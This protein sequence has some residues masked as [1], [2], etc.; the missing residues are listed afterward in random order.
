LLHS[1]V[2][3]RLPHQAEKNNGNNTRGRK[4]SDVMRQVVIISPTT[5]Y[6]PQHLADIKSSGI[7]PPLCPAVELVSF[8][9]SFEWFPRANPRESEKFC[10]PWDGGRSRGAVERR[11]GEKCEDKRLGRSEIRELYSIFTAGRQP[12]QPRHIPPSFT[13]TM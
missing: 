5:R 1:L 9:N 10:K 13:T 7:N 4:R 8:L 12:F 6:F 2:F 11:S 3:W